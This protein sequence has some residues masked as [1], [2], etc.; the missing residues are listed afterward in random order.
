MLVCFCRRL[1]IGRTPM[2]PSKVLGK[3]R[4]FAFSNCIICSNIFTFSLTM[5]ICII[6]CRHCTGCIH[7]H[8][9]KL[10]LLTLQHRRLLLSYDV[11]DYAKV[12]DMYE[13]YMFELPFAKWKSLRHTQLLFGCSNL[14]ATK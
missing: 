4:N 8:L 11:I 3:K 12:G 5:C 13:R 6:G 1:E 9:Q 10:F 2:K 7:R 14:L